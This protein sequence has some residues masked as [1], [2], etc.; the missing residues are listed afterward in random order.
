MI[1]TISRDTAS[2]TTEIQGAPAD[3]IKV[4]PLTLPRDAFRTV[5]TRE[6]IP[7]RVLTVARLAKTEARK[8]IAELIAAM[9]HVR[10]RVSHASLVVVGDGDD[11]ERLEALAREAAVAD[12]VRFAGSLTDSELI[13]EYQAADL[14]ALPSSKEG[15][16]LVFVEAML[17]GTPVIGMDAGGTPDVV[18]PGK[19]G[20]LLR[21]ISELPST[22]STLLADRDQL[23]RM[24]SAAV[25]AA[26]GFS[27]ER[28]RSELFEGLTWE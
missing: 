18:R 2:R 10:R 23:E 5:S 7:G 15:F 4:V 11:R 1:Y 3:R 26:R 8:G 13:G 14:F 25:E 20:L 6:R 12:I 9:A 16:G 19:D 28:F 22:L 27:P 21:N 24:R 17:R